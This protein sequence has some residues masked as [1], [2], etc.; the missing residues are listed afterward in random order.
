MIIIQDK[1]RSILDLDNAQCGRIRMENVVLLGTDS[2]FDHTLKHSCYHVAVGNYYHIPFSFL[3]DD[4]DG[5]PRSLQEFLV[6]LREGFRG[7]S[8]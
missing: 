2:S 4:F 1:K 7:V 8:M 3:P 5:L 6:R